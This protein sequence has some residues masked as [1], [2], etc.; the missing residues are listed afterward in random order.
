[1]VYMIVHKI[2]SFTC[3][4]SVENIT[5]M[6]V[7]MVGQRWLSIPKSPSWFLGVKFIE[8]ALRKFGCV[9]FEQT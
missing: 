7:G 2:R 5:T 1:M 9:L 6:Y 3:L 4:V 8:S